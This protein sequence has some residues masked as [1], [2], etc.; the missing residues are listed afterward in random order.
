MLLQRSNPAK[1]IPDCTSRQI[2]SILADLDAD[3]SVAAV[4]EDVAVE[5]D[6]ESKSLPACFAVATRNAS[7]Q[8]Q[9]VLRSIAAPDDIIWRSDAT[10]TTSRRKGIFVDDCVLK[11]GKW[12]NDA[13]ADQ[14]VLT[15]S[16]KAG[17][18]RKN[19]GLL[20][21]SVPGK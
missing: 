1:G 6:S 17:G 13:R 14:I 20:M 18:F 12:Q 4:F 15:G 3:E 11:G 9:L 16:I 10:T 5:G 8:L 7:Q 21:D 2:R 19:F